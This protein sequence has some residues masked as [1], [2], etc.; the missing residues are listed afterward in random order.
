MSNSA[1]IPMEISK[2]E[3][4]RRLEFMLADQKTH[5]GRVYSTKNI[6][7]FSKVGNSGNRKQRRAAA[8]KARKR[9]KHK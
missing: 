9:S 8:A 5:P 7:T 1:T 2:E 3:A 6:R 4:M